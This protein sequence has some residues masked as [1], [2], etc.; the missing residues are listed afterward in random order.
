MNTRETRVR[1]FAAIEGGSLF[2]SNEIATFGSDLVLEKIISN[3]YRTDK[4]S[5]DFISTEIKNS[6]SQQ[7][8]AEITAAG[9]S[10][11]TPESA[12]W[13]TSL[14]DLIA[15]P[16]GIVIKGVLNSGK[17]VS[18]VG[19]RNPSTYGARVA[20]EFG[21]SFADNGWT[22]ISGGAY[23]IDTAAH[24]GA[25]A[26]EGATYAVLAS[27]VCINYPAANDR[28]FN[29]ISESGALLSEV[30]PNVRAKPERFLARNRLIAALSL[31]TIVVEA[32]FRS[33]SL[34]TA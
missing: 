20:S 15:P 25:L 12:E 30:M 19:T 8:L 10:F 11:I 33:G 5:I 2:W 13:P 32:A 22:V 9:A 1:L 26:G 17:K 24:R 29:E 21:A 3:G 23:G 14:N 34:R 31:G 6:N 7:L 4:N 27:G 16:I 28:L 18:I